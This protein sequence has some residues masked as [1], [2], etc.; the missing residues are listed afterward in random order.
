LLF[1]ISMG[2]RKN[3]FEIIGSLDLR[4]QKG[5]PTLP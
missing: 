1:K 4:P 2:R 3:F 5:K